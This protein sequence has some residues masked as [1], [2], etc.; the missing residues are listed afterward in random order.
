MRLGLLSVLFPLVLGCAGKNTVAGE[1]PNAATGAKTKAEQLS[2]SAPSWCDSTCKRLKA[3]PTVSC[4]CDTSGNACDCPPSISAS[5]QQ[6]CA[7]AMTQFTLDGDACAAVGERFRSC[8]D[9]IGCSELTQGQ[10]CAPSAA[11]Q[12]A[13]PNGNSSGDSAPPTGTSSGGSSSDTSGPNGTYPTAGTAT[14]GAPATG[15]LVSCQSGYGTA[16]AA[17]TSAGPPSSAVVCEEGV[18]DCTDNHQ[19]GWLCAVGSEGQTA[20]S[21]LV[22]LHTTGGFDPGGTT[23]PSQAQVNAGCGWNIAM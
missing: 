5:C 13:C 12:A 21:C 11:D 7:K 10:D 22:D 2:A 18:A 8:V 23:C 3:C 15:P 20:C 17:G 9:A 1:D 19:Y 14:G 16:G 4:N 6:D